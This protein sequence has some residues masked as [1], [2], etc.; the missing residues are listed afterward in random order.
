MEDVRWKMEKIAEKMPNACNSQEFF[1]SL[2][3][4]T[5][6][7][8]GGTWLCRP[9]TRLGRADA[10]IALRSLLRRFGNEQARCSRLAL[11]L[12]VEK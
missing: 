2:Q 12:S 5:T 9:P 10:S 4:K 6:A 7:K 1:L 11:T 3:S 8:S